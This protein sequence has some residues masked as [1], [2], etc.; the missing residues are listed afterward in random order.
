M[1][2]K[3]KACSL[4]ELIKDGN[5]QDGLDIKQLKYNISSITRFIYIT[6]R[7]ECNSY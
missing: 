7:N 1:V 3:L 2:F 6:R 4:Y 5:Y